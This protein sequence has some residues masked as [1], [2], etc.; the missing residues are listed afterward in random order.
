MPG[1]IEIVLYELCLFF[2]RYGHAFG[3]KGNSTVFI[4][5]DWC[6]II[7]DMARLYFALTETLLGS[8]L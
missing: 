1:S 2:D 4:P 3:L 8:V 5:S 7:V 6:L